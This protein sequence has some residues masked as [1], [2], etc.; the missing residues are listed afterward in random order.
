LN[1]F[2]STNYITVYSWLKHLF[3]HH[4]VIKIKISTDFSNTLDDRA[5]GEEF[6]IKFLE[7]IFEDRKNIDM[8]EI[9]FDDTVGYST[10]FLHEV[11]HVLVQKFGY[12]N[13][14]DRLIFVS[15]DDPLLTTEI[16]RYMKGH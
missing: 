3:P 10:A 9:N 14:K 8:I 5:S 7:T 4:D 15:N 2:L 13:C 11:F 6:R 16:E 12:K 1:E